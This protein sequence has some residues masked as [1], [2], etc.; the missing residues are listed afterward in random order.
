MCVLRVRNLATAGV[1]DSTFNIISYFIPAATWPA[2]HCML[3]VGPAEGSANSSLRGHNHDCAPGLRGGEMQPWGLNSAQAGG[4]AKSAFRFQSQIPCSFTASR[5]VFP[6]GVRAWG[7][8][9]SGARSWR[10]YMAGTAAH[11]FLACRLP[12]Q[13][14]GCRRLK[15]QARI[16]RVF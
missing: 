14:S 6:S 11:P 1:P 7:Q 5:T 12:W 10:C 15:P 13:L 8:A 9:N 4:T 3:R 2:P 16:C